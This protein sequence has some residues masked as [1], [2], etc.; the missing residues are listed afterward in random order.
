MTAT[1]PLMTMVIQA[2]WATDMPPAHHLPDVIAAAFPP[3][4]GTTLDM[5]L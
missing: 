1:A 2:R 5:F 3:A 4:A